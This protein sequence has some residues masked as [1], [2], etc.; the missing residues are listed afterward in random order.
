MVGGVLMIY[1]GYVSHSLLYQ[2]ADTVALNYLDLSG[3]AASTV[4]LAISILELLNALGGITVII[5]G[6]V[7]I[8]GHGRTGRLII[9][10]GGGAGLLGL[11]VSFGYASYKLGLDQTLSYAYYWIGL[12][13]AVGARM[14]SKGARNQV[15]VPAPVS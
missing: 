14:V 8:S 3:F 6:L 12:I 13:L 15:K 5:G 9:L 2:A 7:L 11:L 1:S 10:L 4:T